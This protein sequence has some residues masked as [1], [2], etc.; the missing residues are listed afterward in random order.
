MPAKGKPE[1]NTRSAGGNNGYTEHTEHVE[2][3]RPEPWPGIRGR[4]KEEERELP[5]GTS[6]EEQADVT[7]AQRQLEEDVGEPGPA[8]E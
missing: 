5:T 2:A 8:R 3:P 6:R 1:E 4:S 7:N